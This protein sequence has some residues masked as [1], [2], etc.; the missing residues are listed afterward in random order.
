MSMTQHMFEMINVPT[1]P[2]AIQAD[3][4]RCAPR[5]TNGHRDG[6][7][8]TLPTEWGAKGK[9]DESGPTWSA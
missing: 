7:L 6:L 1:T 9:Y 3:L 8:C 5:R 2:V 4:Y